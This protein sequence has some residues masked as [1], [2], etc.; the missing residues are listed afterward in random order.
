VSADRDVTAFDERATSYDDGWL[1]RLH[2]DVAKRTVAVAL[3][4]KPGSTDL[5]PV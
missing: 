4:S 1:G 2:H 5:G 3:A